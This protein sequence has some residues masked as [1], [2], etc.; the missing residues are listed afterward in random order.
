LRIVEESF[1]RYASIAERAD[2]ERLIAEAQRLA[3]ISVS[4]LAVAG[5]A[6]SNA[7]LTGAGA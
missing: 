4:R 2:D 3:S 6:R 7:L 5:G 1:D